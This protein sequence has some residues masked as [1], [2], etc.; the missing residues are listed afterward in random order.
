MPTKLTGKE[1]K[2]L[3]KAER[4]QVLKAKRQEAHQK[5]ITGLLA[6][7]NVIEVSETTTV[8]TKPRVKE[9]KVYRDPQKILR[10][11]EAEKRRVAA[12]NRTPEEQIQL[13]DNRLGVGV[14]ATKERKKLNDL[15]QAK[16]GKVKSIVEDTSKEVVVKPRLK[17]KERRAKEKKGK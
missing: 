12:S 9:V 15:I 13:L 8:F 1:K 6:G 5:L 14:G 11:T 7:D 16:I 10:V 3:T 17:A 4:K 2:G